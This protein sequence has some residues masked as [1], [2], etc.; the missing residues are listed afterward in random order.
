[1]AAYVISEISQI[2]EPVLL[3]EYRSLAQATIEQY[4]GRYVVRGGAIEA[5]EGRPLPKRIVIV[6][7]P[8]MEQARSG[9]TRL[10]TLKPCRSAR[11]P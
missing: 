6:E 7:F 3:E 11:R 2:L 1:M 10:S 4:G 8:T 5:V 9:I